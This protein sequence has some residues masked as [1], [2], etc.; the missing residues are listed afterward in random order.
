MM[1]PSTSHI[2]DTLEGN[3]SL[4]KSLRGDITSLMRN[5]RRGARK[6][7]A[8]SH[9]KDKSKN[10]IDRQ[11]KSLHELVDNQETMYRKFETLS[12]YTTKVMHSMTKTLYLLQVNNEEN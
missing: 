5:S 2:Y 7:E 12:E 1:Y 8:P 10:G 4:D 9:E 11:E 6:A 3:P